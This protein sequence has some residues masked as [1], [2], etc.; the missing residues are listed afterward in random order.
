[1]VIFD[2]CAVLAAIAMAAAAFPAIRAARVDPIAA[3]RK[4]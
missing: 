1:M 2:A 4:D 3:L